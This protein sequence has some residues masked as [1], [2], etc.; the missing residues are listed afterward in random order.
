LQTDY[1]DLYQFHSGN[2]DMFDTPG[3]W[4]VLREQVRA[5]KVR[6]LGNSVSRNDNVYQVD[7][8]TEVGVEAIQVIYNRL[9]RKPDDGLLQSC[10]RQNLG[11]LARVPLASGYL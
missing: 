7:R 5:G 4:E 9:D 3:L 2:N 1:V 11:V 6:H 10:Q 8:S